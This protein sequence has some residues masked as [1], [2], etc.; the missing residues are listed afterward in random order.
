MRGDTLEACFPLATSFGESYKTQF[1][2]CNI[3]K[4]LKH[5]RQSAH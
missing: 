2:A 5:P 4:P 3:F 1:F